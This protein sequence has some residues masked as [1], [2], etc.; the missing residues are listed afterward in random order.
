[1][2]TA[3][4]AIRLATILDRVSELAGAIGKPIEC[5]VGKRFI[6]LVTGDVSNVPL[7]GG[8][9]ALVNRHVHAFVEIET[10]D[11][12]KAA[13]WKAPAKGARGNILDDADF[14]RILS[15]ADPYGSYLYRNR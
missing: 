4:E 11:L 5:E 15:V 3:A 13:G 10:G 8:G 12:L 9:F 1:M 7:K 2:T 14:A 6:R